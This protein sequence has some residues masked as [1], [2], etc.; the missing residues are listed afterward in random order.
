MNPAK[1]TKM[2]EEVQKWSRKDPLAIRR[3]MV[4]PEHLEAL[5]RGEMKHGSTGD[6]DL[7]VEE[8]LE[9]DGGPSD[10]DAEEVDEEVVEPEEEEEEEENEEDEEEEDDDVELIEPPR[11]TIDVDAESFIINTPESLID[12]EEDGGDQVDFDLEVPD[13]YGNIN[14]DSKDSTLALELTEQD[15]LS[16]EDEDE[17][18]YINQREC[19]APEQMVLILMG[20]SLQL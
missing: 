9:S 16:L 14:V 13:F 4:H 6:D 12:G 7:D 19:P 15:L 5:E 2:D 17:S 11:E 18:L 20:C 8:D 3:A 1:I 10:V